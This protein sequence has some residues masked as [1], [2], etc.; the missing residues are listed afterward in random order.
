MSARQTLNRFKTWFTEI[1]DDIVQST[2]SILRAA[3]GAVLATC[4]MVVAVGY[5]YVNYAIPYFAP[6]DVQIASAERRVRLA[7]VAHDA[8]ESSRIA[9]AKANV[10]VET[11]RLQV[12]AQRATLGIPDDSD[13]PVIAPIRAI[14]E[15]ISNHISTILAIV[16]AF[17]VYETVA[18]S[19]AVWRPVLLV[20]ILSVLSGLYCL[21]TGAL[22]ETEVNLE[23]KDAVATVNTTSTGL[24][25]ILLGVVLAGFAAWQRQVEQ[26]QIGSQLPAANPDA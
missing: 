20:A 16:L 5:T 3:M 13:K 10:E 6:S 24:C 22:A 8:I 9:S 12:A 19:S 2:P 14:T 17:L 23:W 4:V 18:H 11:S 25:C 26:R 21:V 7:Q 15:L 1:T